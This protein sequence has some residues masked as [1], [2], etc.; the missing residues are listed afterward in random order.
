MGPFHYW[1]IYLCHDKLRFN[2]MDKFPVKHFIKY[3][4]VTLFDHYAL[5]NN[6]NVVVKPRN[7]YFVPVPLTNKQ[8]TVLLIGLCHKNWFKNSLC[9]IN[10]NDYPELFI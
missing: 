10:I 3:N 9:D 5:T 2:T 6:G 8:L 1:Y 7:L 4:K